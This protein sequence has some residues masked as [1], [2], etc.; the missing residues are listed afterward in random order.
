[1]LVT[2]LSASPPQRGPVLTEDNLRTLS[3]ITAA[4]TPPSKDKDLPSLPLPAYPPTSAGSST[5][6]SHSAKKPHHHH[7]HRLSLAPH[8]PTTPHLRKRSSTLLA[9]VTRPTASALASTAS[10][11]RPPRLLSR[12]D[13]LLTR[14]HTRRRSTHPSGGP[15]PLAAIAA[16]CG[17]DAGAVAAH[18]RV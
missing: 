6:S 8:P 5:R 12:V 15:A 11:T 2:E 9:L 10:T 7:H 3:H 13:T 4:T 17:G 18:A 1:M 16:H 14:T